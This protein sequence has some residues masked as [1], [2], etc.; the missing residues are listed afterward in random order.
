MRC[1]IVIIHSVRALLFWIKETASHDGRFE[2]GTRI[3]HM[4]NKKSLFC[5]WC[6]S[7][8]NANV[9]HN[10]SCFAG[11]SLVA[12]ATP[13]LEKLIIMSINPVN[14]MTFLIICGVWP[15]SQR[16]QVRFPAIAYNFWGVYCLERDPASLVRTIWIVAW[17]E[18]Y[19]NEIRLRK[20]KIKIK[21]CAFYPNMHC[22]P[23]ANVS[24]NLATSKL[25]R[26]EFEE[27]E[28]SRAILLSF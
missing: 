26:Q 21:G 20:L 10:Q 7:I 2:A 13:V 15:P 28:K 17:Y 6:P 23:A 19:S 8:V 25:S 18:K 27:V 12:L 24:V 16:S 14:V 5:N 9:F 1:S 4:W 22:H 11:V 3:I